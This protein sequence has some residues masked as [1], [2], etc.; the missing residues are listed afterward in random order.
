MGN[1][2]LLGVLIQLVYLDVS[3]REIYWIKGK[4][5]T[6][7]CDLPNPVEAQL[8]HLPRVVIQ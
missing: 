3:F 4:G 1:F 5:L 2:R 8:R 7:V 6:I